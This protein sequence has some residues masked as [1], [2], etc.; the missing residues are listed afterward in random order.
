M[1]AKPVPCY[2]RIGAINN[3]VIM[4]LQCTYYSTSME[5]I[6]LSLTVLEKMPVKIMKA[7]QNGG[8]LPFKGQ[9]H[10]SIFF[11][12]RKGTSSHQTEWFEILCMKI[13]SAV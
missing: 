13:G 5:T 7:A 6:S 8:I 4:R 11:Y 3:R 10:E 1:G 9:G 2:N 12:H